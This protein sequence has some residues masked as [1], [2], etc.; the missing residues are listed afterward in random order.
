M[1]KEIKILKF[2]PKQKDVLSQEEIL[3]VF[4]GL[5]RLVQKSAELS[6]FEKSK[7]QIEYYTKKLNETTFEL[8]KRNKQVEELL[9]LNNQLISQIQS[10]S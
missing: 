10:K 2:Q 8:N 9:D 7:K 1:E 5:V 4:G 6:A 3:K